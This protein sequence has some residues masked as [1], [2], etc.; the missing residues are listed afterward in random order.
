[1]NFDL[2]RRDFL[3]S[4]TGASTLLMMGNAGP[5]PAFAIPEPKQVRMLGR[6][7]WRPTTATRIV[8][9]AVWLPEAQRLADDLVTCGLSRVRPQVVARG[10]RRGD[11]LI[12]HTLGGGAEAYRLTIEHDQVRIEAGDAA[13]VYY[14]TRS[15]LQRLMLAGSVPVAVVEDAPDCPQRGVMVDVGR[16]Y[17]S[18]EWLERLI[19]RMGWLK[20]NML[21][22]HLT[23]NEGFGYSSAIDHRLASP[24]HLS[25]DDL[26]SLVAH[27][28]RHHVTLVPELDAPGH[29]ASVI[30]LYPEL[31]LIAA[32]GSSTGRAIDVSMPAARTL[33]DRFIDELLPIFPGP[34][35]HLGGDEVLLTEKPDHSTNELDVLFP[36]LVRHAALASGPG[37]T[38]HDALSLH[39]N[40]MQI[41][42]AAH[43]KRCRAWND[44][45]QGDG[46]VALD[47]RIEI[48]YW[49]NLGGKLKTPQQHITEGFRLLNAHSRYL[50]HVL[51]NPPFPWYPHPTRDKMLDEWSVTLFEGE[52]LPIASSPSI[53]GAH[54][55]VWADRPEASSEQEIERSLLGP[56][57][58]LAEK[59]WNATPPPGYDRVGFVRAQQQLSRR[60][61]SRSIL[62]SGKPDWR[63]MCNSEHATDRSRS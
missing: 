17:Y 40:A 52:K 34:V 43:G 24:L 8:T 15:L 19:V 1:M 56:T 62:A 23:D 27:G 55:A 57:F 14:A 44:G 32:D 51:A 9:A 2:H 6:D 21:H 5:A 7:N 11:I 12:G 13:G 60:I 50:Y 54:L 41:R 30:R 31:A 33:L 48:D 61:D 46:I 35:W 25:R 3:L 47:R 4:A 29:L 37:A 26:R 59:T 28:K 53:L 36:Q 18:R 39:L 20:L 10:P 22:L 42:L 16:K 45:M 49:E 63:S 58:A 38:A